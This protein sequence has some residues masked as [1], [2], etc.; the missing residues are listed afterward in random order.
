VRIVAISDGSGCAE[1]PDGLDSDELKR[2]VQGCLPISRFDVTRLGARGRIV[3]IDQPGGI[4]LRNTLHERVI[5]DAFIPAGGRP[6]TINENNW[7]NFLLPDGQ[8]SSRVIVEGANLF[9]TPQAR[10]LLSDRGV[11]IIKDS[12]ANKAG[13]ICSSFEIVASML[14][15]EPG[16]L[17]I[18][19]RYVKEVLDKLR[20]LAHLEALTLLREHSH[21]PTIRLPVLSERLS[22]TINR[23]TDTIA[24]AVDGW[25]ARHADLVQQVLID[26]LPASLY[27]TVGSKIFTEIPEAYL[28]RIIASAL[29]SRIVYREGLDWIETMPE[30]NI[31]QLAERY[32]VEEGNMHV[33]VQEIRA[34]DCPNRERIALLLES[35][36]TATA[37][38]LTQA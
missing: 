38:K 13:V 14:L 19:H 32:L 36:G 21:K 18:K 15:D 29:A 25:L 26:Y 11:L 22:R 33:L 35:G 30:E 3:E 6:G 24:T 34:S 7:Q 17:A 27:E 16:F 1:D 4:H 31:A 5:A 8:P 10:A 20:A 23:A 12:S 9:V 28:H 2:L 37:L